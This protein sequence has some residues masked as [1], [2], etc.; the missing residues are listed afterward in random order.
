M[1]LFFRRHGWWLLM[2]LILPWALASQVRLQTGRYP[3]FCFF[4]INCRILRHYLWADLPIR[5]GQGTWSAGLILG[6]VLVIVFFVRVNAVRREMS[7]SQDDEADG[8]GGSRWTI[9]RLAQE[10]PK[11][12]AVVGTLVLTTFLAFT[13]PV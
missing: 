11:R 8:V 4:F 9:I 1:R 10:V 12:H 7:G 6:V 2:V 5:L 3:I 13:L